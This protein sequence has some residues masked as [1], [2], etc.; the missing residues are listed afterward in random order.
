[1]A[2]KVIRLSLNK[3]Q[4]DMGTS[5]VFEGSDMACSMESKTILQRAF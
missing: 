5:V 3:M 2:L 1:M 4:Y